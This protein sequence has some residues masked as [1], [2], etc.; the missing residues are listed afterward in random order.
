MNKKIKMVIA[1]ID[2]T[3]AEHSILSDFTIATINQIHDAGLLFGIASGRP[4]YQL[5]RTIKEW[6]LSFEPDA[7]IGMNGAQLFDKTTGEI[8]AINYMSIEE[9]R[10]GIEFMRPFY[11][12]TNLFIYR[13]KGTVFQKEDKVYLKALDT[14]GKVEG[15]L[16]AENEE[17]FLK[18]PNAKLL[19]RLYDTSKMK[20]IEDY[21]ASHEHPEFV[22][23]K[24]QENLYELTNPKTNKGAAVKRF[25]QK[26]GLSLD[27]IAGFGDMDNDIEMIDVCGM[28]V[29]LVNGCDAAKAVAKYITE[30]DCNHH[31]FANFVHKYIL[32]DD[33]RGE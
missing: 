12:D 30:E 32:E 1:D 4:A 17:E 3:L 28:G 5:S 20:E 10:K 29:C 7:I 25:A 26:N 6:T 19:Y 16:I 21:V 27:E 22:G 31:G 23:F 14:Y 18:E 8:E 11:N 2:G 13:G 9:M 24:T 15:C 33:L